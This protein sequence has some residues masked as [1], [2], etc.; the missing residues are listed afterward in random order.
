MSKYIVS[1]FQDNIGLNGSLDEIWDGVSNQISLPDGSSFAVMEGSS[2]TY[3]R[4]Q[5][6]VIIHLTSASIFLD[7]PRRYGLF[8]I[9][10]LYADG[11]AYRFELY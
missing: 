5:Y 1:Q 7:S 6:C 3:Y 10:G 2:V 11:E 9:E 4:A 8:H